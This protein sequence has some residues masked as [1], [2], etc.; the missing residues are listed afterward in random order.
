MKNVFVICKVRKG[1]GR[2]NSRHPK[3]M[4]APHQL[5][6]LALLSLSQS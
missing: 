4:R 2:G 6:N 1:V 3:G 5:W